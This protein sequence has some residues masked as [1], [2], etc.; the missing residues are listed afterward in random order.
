LKTKKII[1]LTGNNNFFGQTR[2]PWVSMD[3][4]K[5]QQLIREHGLD[6][7]K[8]SFQE[9]INQEKLFKD[10]IIFYA[11][12]Q[13]QNRREYIKD[14]IRYLDDGSNILIPGY[15]LLL[16]HENKGF[17]E[18]YKKRI[19][20]NSLKSYYLTDDKDLP[21][22]PINF[23]VVLKTVDTSNGKGVFL[24]KSNNELIN[25]IQRL[26]RQNILTRL[27][28]M[29][30][31]YFRRKKS[32][33]EYPDY[34][35][36]KDYY[37]YKDYILKE[38]NF[39]LQEFVPN[40]T[41]DYR[42]LILYDKYYV[43]KRYTKKNDFRASG[44]KIQEYDIEIDYSLLDYARKVYEKFDTPF[45]SLDIGI[46]QHSYCLFEFQAL[47]FGINVLVKSVGFYTYQHK[48]WNFSSHQNRIDI[49][50]EMATAF[51]KYVTARYFQD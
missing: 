26:E 41:Y 43:M 7:E 4:E 30:R 31:K 36:R 16:C 32:Y 39:I 23:P 46:H 15:D 3:S 12:S 48:N 24:A 35:N 49:E 18:L 29:R 21:D 33:K 47:H 51:V 28:L 42:V 45:L 37:Q 2:K 1:L 20:L 9:V 50:S 8:Y 38:K 5:L 13:K 34:S 10:S 25:I 27:D 22:Y 17:Q 14:I 19:K 44:T 40:L 6:I 11:F